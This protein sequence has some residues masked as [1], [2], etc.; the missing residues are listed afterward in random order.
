M[1]EIKVGI[2]TV[3][4]SCSAGKSEDISGK[5]LAEFVVSRFGN[6]GQ[7]SILL[8]LQFYIQAV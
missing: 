5:N 6:A 2:L 4:D 1:D 8:V 7:L 3:S